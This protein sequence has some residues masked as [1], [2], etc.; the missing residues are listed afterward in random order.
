LKG[1]WVDQHYNLMTGN[2]FN[3][4]AFRLDLENALL[5]HDPKLELKQQWTLELESIHQHTTRLKGYKELEKLPDYPE[6]IK[7]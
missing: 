3:P 1:L 5:I 4:R 7:N 2:N 6:K